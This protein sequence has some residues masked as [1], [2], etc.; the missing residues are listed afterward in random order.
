MVKLD[1]LKFYINSEVGIVL[2]LFLI[3]ADFERRCF[4]EILLIKKECSSGQII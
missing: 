2:N 3:F 1:V 4:Y